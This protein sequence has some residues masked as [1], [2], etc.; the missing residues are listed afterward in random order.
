[1]QQH[2]TIVRLVMLADFFPL[3]RTTDVAQA[4]IFAA[5]FVQGN[6]NAGR[7]HG[8]N[9]PILTVLV[10]GHFLAIASRLTKQAHVPQREVGAG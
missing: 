7:C 6:P 8:A 4:T 10:P 5:S 1:M 3:M 9:G 2:V